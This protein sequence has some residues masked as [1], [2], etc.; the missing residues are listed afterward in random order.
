MTARVPLGGSSPVFGGT[1][2]GGPVSGGLVFGGA[3]IGGLYAPVTDETADE[4]LAAAWAAGIRA[5]DTAPHYGSG[6]SEQR[7]GTFLAGRP[8]DEFVLSTKVGRL[9]VPA[10]GDTEGVEG[11]YGAPPLRRI[12]DYSRDGVLR[13]LEESLRRLG[14]DRVDIALIHDPDDFLDQAVDGA[15]RPWPNSAPRARSGPSARA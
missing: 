9:L 10:A 7:I 14:L 13:S 4:T 11:F 2:R 6:L 8:R 15:Y 12:R 1:V 3:P 5:F